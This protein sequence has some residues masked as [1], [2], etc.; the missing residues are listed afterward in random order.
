ME[1]EGEF[2][3]AW[4]FLSDGKSNIAIANCPDDWSLCSLV[5]SSHGYGAPGISRVML[6][7]SELGEVIEALQR[8]KVDMRVDSL[9]E[10]EPT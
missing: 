2:E 4:L 9:V 1:R 8:V 10:L 5:M 3:K 7:E 6:T